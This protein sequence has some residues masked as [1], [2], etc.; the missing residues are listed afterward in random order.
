MML[1]SLMKTTLIKGELK[2][3]CVFLGVLCAAEQSVVAGKSIR[4]VID[5]A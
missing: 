4:S 1:M 2:I 5:L 3:L